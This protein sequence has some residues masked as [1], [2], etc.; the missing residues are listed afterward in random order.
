MKFA[1]PGSASVASATI[2]NMAA[3]TGARS[4]SPPI[5]PQVVAAARARR[6]QRDDEEQ[7]H[8]HEPVVDH[9]QHRT[10]G[11]RVGE[12]EDPERD[13][14][15]AARSTSTRRPASPTSG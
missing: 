15:R 3:S 10:L 5:L 11:A 8:H 9:L 6:Q 2:R 14:A 7:R 4:A 12:R 1:E 13:E